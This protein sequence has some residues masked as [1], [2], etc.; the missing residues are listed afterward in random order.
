MSTA[1]DLSQEA[2]HQ[3]A[4]DARSLLALTTPDGKRLNELQAKHVAVVLD[5]FQA[6]GTMGKL[7][8]NFTENSI[9]EDLFATCKDRHEIGRSLSWCFS[10]SHSCFSSACGHSSPSTNSVTH[11]LTRLGT[12]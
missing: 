3:P 1:A 4:T 9:Y 7:N 6:K 2:L 5:M 10:L 12:A 11:C 8:D